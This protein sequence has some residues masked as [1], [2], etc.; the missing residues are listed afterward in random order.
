MSSDALDEYIQTTG[1]RDIDALRFAILDVVDHMLDHE[2]KLAAEDARLARLSRQYLND[3]NFTEVT[4]AGRFPPLEKSR[5]YDGRIE[6]GGAVADKYYCNPH[7][8]VILNGPRQAT[9]KLGI[10]L[11]YK[12]VLHPHVMRF[13][14]FKLNI[15]IDAFGVDLTQQRELLKRVFV[16]LKKDQSRFVNRMNRYCDDLERAVT[17]QLGE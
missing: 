13:G 3:W 12:K 5:E 9:F 15:A 16:Y 4:V 1:V 10:Y 11:D 14:D 2:A 17:A 6:S 8:R 7:M